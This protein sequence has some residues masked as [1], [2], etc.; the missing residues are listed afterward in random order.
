MTARHHHYLSQCYLKG[1]TKGRAKKSKLTVVDFKEKKRFETTPRN[2]GGIRDF[3]RVDID[4]I[5]QNAIEKSL[6]EF[7]GQAA[8]ALKKL[9]RGARFS[10]EIRELILNLIA[11]FAIRSP[12]RREHMRTILADTADKIMGLTLGSKEGWESQIAKLRKKDPSYDNDV[13]YEQ[14]KEFHDRKEYTIEVAREYHIHNEIAQVDAILPSL[15]ARNWVL[16]EANE[17]TGPFITTDNPI[18]LTWNEPNT[19]PPMFRS[20]PG[21]GCKST[22]V[23]FPVSQDLALIGEFEAEDKTIKGSHELIALLNTRMLSNAYKQIYSPKIDFSFYGK[24]GE[25]LLGNRILSELN[26]PE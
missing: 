25:I 16:V 2:V 22:Q 4:G 13:A 10:G 20:S 7:E 12:E 11:L 5:D 14:A 17:E 21:F 8:S 15:F 26:N 1:F 19:I 24:D 23:L 6:A 18:S 9:H 3:N